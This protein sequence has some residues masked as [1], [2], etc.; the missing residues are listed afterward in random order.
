MGKKKKR[1]AEIMDRTICPFCGNVLFLDVLEGL[2]TVCCLIMIKAPW[3]VFHEGFG[4][5]SRRG[6]HV[7]GN[8]SD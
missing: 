5:Q 7:S 8:A 4:V 3:S 1:A 2:T 6:Y